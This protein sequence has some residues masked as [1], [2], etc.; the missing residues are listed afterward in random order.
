MAKPGLISQS[1]GNLTRG[2]IWACTIFMDYYTNYVFVALM[3]DLTAESTL[4]ARKEFKH[5]CAVRGIKVKPY[6]AD[7]GLFAKPAWINKCK[8]CHWDLTFCGVGSHHQNGIAEHAIKQVT[9]IYRKILLHTM[10]YEPEY[11]N[12]SV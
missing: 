3:R 5:R 2:R 9:L 10:Q 1:K 12:E 7:N 4:V 6:H 8:R 11:Y